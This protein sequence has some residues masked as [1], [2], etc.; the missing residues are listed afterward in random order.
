GISYGIIKYCSN[1]EIKDKIKFN[2][3]PEICFNYLG[4]FDEDINN[5]LFNASPLSSGKDFCLNNNILYSLDFLAILE[6]KRLKLNVRY[7]N[8]EY[9]D[10]TI[11]VVADNYMINLINIINHCS[12]KNESEKT[13]ADITKEDITLSDLKPYLKDI[14]NIKNIYEL[15]PM[16]EGMLYHTL[17]DEGSEAYHNALTLKIKG[18]LD[19]AILEGSF[20][21]LIARHDILRTTFDSKNF[22]KNMQIVFNERKTNVIYQDISKRNINKEDY[23]N[24]VIFEDKKNRF[25]LDKDMLIRLAVIKVDKD[26]YRFVLSNHHIILDGWCLS[27]L[28]FELFKIYNELKYGYDSNLPEAVPYSNYIDWLN[29][30]DYDSAEEYWKDYLL[31]YNEV[32]EIP[33]KNSL[34]KEDFKNSELTFTLDQN[35]V[36]KL[37][38]IAQNSKVT[39]NTIMQ[40]IWSILLQK[41]NNTKDVVFGYVVSG[42]NPEV[43]G[44]ENMLGLFINTIPL[45]I[46]LED[47]ISFKDL[48]ISINKSFLESNEYDFYPLAKIQS[49]SEVKD[50]L[51][52][53]IMVFENYPVDG[54]GLNTEL[55]VKN[56]LQIIDFDGR[57]QTNYNFNLIVCYKDIIS[58]KFQFNELLYSTDNVEKMKNH[59]IHLIDEIITNENVLVKDLEILGQD[60]KNKLLLEFNQT[61]AD[62]PNNKT[63]QELFEEQVSK[64]PNNIAVVFESKSITYKE[65][66]ERSNSL[67]SI[68]RNNG[69]GPD[70]IV[71]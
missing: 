18:D 66:N 22:N 5:S 69:V 33:F 19:I 20:N 34:E 4:Q 40:S 27:I 65:L 41:Y 13:A 16:Q 44:I 36:K 25:N 23:I 67:A 61:K 26:I 29:S 70:D 6:N 63:I 24:N 31:D 30:K 28:I 55:L 43:K 49:F 71:G 14:N 62:Y 11:K 51:V 48:L 58:I 53:N 15:S 52:N 64:T 45:R 2:L 10:E 56:D 8:N 17:A 42:R 37:E 47:N 50:K 32:T 35:I 59:F 57:E 9:K 60:E 38:R 46:K 1:S 7:S 12:N 54:E 39:I 21:K 68:L 3:N